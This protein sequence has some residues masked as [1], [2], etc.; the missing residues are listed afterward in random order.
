MKVYPPT[1]DLNLERI[2]PTDVIAK[3]RE[4]NIA[5]MAAFGGWDMDQTYKELTNSAQAIAMGVQIADFA[6]DNELDGVSI[7]HRHR[8]RVRFGVQVTFW[9]DLINS[10]RARCIQRSV[11]DMI[12]SIALPAVPANG[13]DDSAAV[14]EQVLAAYTA[15]L[16]EKIDT[17]VDFYNMMTY[18]MPNRYDKGKKAQHQASLNGTLDTIKYYSGVGL[19][20]KKSNSGTPVWFPMAKCDSPNGLGCLLDA[21]ITLDNAG[22]NRFRAEYNWENPKWAADKATHPSY[23]TSFDNSLKSMQKYITKDGKVGAPNAEY[24]DPKAKA[25]T[26]YDKDLKI[27]WTWQGPEAIAETC[28]GVIDSDIG[29]QMIFAVG[30]DSTDLLHWDAWMGCVRGW[31]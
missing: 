11:P 22:T 4:K 17:S 23:D 24:Y 21:D 20:P 8:W 2:W 28:K 3:A 30:M 5:V 18:D 31:K 29:G 7:G 1:L 12:I 10:I 9:P 16:F 25:D 13:I 19:S 15:P 26:Y 6:I 14:V 27:F